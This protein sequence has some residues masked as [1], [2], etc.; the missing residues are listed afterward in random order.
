VQS[1]LPLHSTQVPTAE[2]A[3]APGKAEQS[4]SLVQPEQ[5]WF[6]SQVGAP[7]GQS[8]LARHWTQMPPPSSQN[9]LDPEQSSSPLHSVQAPPVEQA[10]A[11]G[12]PKQS[13]SSVQLVH[14]SV[15]GLQTGAA[16]V[17]S[18]LSTH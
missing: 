15:A 11:P 1:L 3:V 8:E 13:V 16:A 7:A 12:K 10:V 17:Q 5:V 6:E 4:A 9:P 2:Q 14:V 18:S